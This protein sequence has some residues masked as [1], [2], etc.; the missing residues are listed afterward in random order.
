M[1]NMWTESLWATR[2]E[3]VTVTSGDDSITR[4]ISV[5]MTIKGDKGVK[6]GELY[7]AL[8]QALDNLMAVEKEKWLNTAVLERERVLLHKHINDMDAVV[9]GQLQ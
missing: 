8:D 2:K 6:S 5:G 9:T 3:S 1:S 7:A 4:D